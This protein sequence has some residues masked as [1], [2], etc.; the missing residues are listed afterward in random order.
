YN[1]ITWSGNYINASTQRNYGVEIET[2]LAI[3]SFTIRANYAYTD[4]QI[5]GRYS[6]TG[7]LLGKDT[8]YF[9]LYRIPKHA[10]NMSASYSS[11]QWLYTLSARAASKRQEF[12]Y[13]ATPALMSGYATIDFYGEYRFKNIN[14]LR[15][16]ADLRNITNTRYEELRGYTARGFTVMAG[17]LFSR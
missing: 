14:G 10:L 3:H 16:F 12:I 11:G 8:S 5:E 6:G 4:G 13:G 17:L 7:L 1:P 9:N 15:A 2:Q